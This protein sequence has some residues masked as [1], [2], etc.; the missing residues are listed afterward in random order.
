MDTLLTQEDLCQYL[1]ISTSSLWRL[2]THAGLP[3]L[4]IG[5]C[6]RYRLNEVEKWLQSN[7]YVLQSPELC[8]SEANQDDASSITSINKETHYE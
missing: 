8:G 4:A 1:K 7:S 2:R 3:Y 6:L 5:G